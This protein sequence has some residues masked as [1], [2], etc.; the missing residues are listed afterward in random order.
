LAPSE[1]VLTG[2]ATALALDPG[3]AQALAGLGVTP[4]PIAPAEARADGRVA[5]PI[6]RGRVD[7]ASLAGE[8]RHRGGLALTAGATRVE[9]TDFTIAIDE[10]PSL[11]GEVGGQRV[12][13]FSL[14][15]S[16]ARP[17]V[18]GRRVSVGGV[19][20]RLTAT[21]AQALNAA[22]GTTALAE[23]LLVRTATVEGRAR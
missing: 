20:V 12:E 8:V 17:A 5:F 14:D 16:A 4:S 1:I 13:L 23:G 22:F 10:T 7:A 3:T 6:T 11:T 2:G 15:L 18:D 9:L 21:A 19:A